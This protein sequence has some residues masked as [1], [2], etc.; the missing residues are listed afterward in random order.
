MRI[1]S[2]GC[3][4]TYGTELS[5]NGMC[6][7]WPKASQLTWPALIAKSLA[8]SYKCLA[9]GGAGNLLIC[10][11]VLDHSWF[12]PHDFLIINWTFCDRF[13]YSHPDG[14]HFNK[15][16][17]IDYATLRP[18]DADSLSNCYYK[19]LHSEFKDKFTNLIYIKM[20][21]DRLLEKKVRFIMTSI[22]DT[23]MQQKYHAPPYVIELQ[24]EIKPWLQFFE[25]KNFLDWSRSSNF[26]ITAAG[27][28]LEDAHA[29]AADIMLPIVQSLV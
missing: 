21:I 23:L 20:V 18:G 28:P 11:R 9:H 7:D 12:H 17:R 19:H 13:D 29:A 5:D 2:F 3:S 27:H 10:N 8:S 25:G 15:A 24:R 4:L 1:A 16:R 26:K 6:D 14:Y 22:D